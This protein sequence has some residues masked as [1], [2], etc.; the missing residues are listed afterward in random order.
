MLLIESEMPVSKVSSLV[1]TTAPRIW[2][3]FDFWINL[4][5]S[6]DDLSNVTQIGMD[7]TSRKKGHNYVTVFADLE[8][9]RVVHDCEGKDA[10]TVES[11][12]ESLEEKGG[13]K[14]NIGLVCRDMSPAFISG[15]RETLSDA[16]I[17]FDK[18]HLVQSLNKSLDE[19][20]IAEH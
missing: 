4:A 6:K 15:V 12:V 2:R 19:V 14:E 10:A 7:E 16:C 17:V 20:R 3:V 1:N 8:S 13:D 11:F 18:F 9:H 5:V